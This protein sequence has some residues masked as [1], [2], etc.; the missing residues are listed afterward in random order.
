VALVDGG[1][2]V[3]GCPLCGGPTVA[4]FSTRDRNRA[5]AP[6]V[7]D[8]LRCVDCG[9]FH[10]DRVP[11]DLGPFYADEYFGLPGLDDLRAQAVAEH[12][13]IDLVRRHTVAAGRLVEIGPGDGIFALQALD[14]GFD[15]AA[16][17]PDRAAAAHLRDVLGVDVV[18]SAAP[19]DELAA[20]GPAQAIVAWH[21]LEHVRSP[22]AVLDAAA[23]TLLP[24]GVLVIATP[25]PRAF[26]FRVLG[27][28]W[29]HVDA[30]RHLFLLPHD[31][32]IERARAAGL[33][34]VE[35]TATDPGG[36]HWNA[37][38]WHYLLRRPGALYVHERVA[39]LA[40]AA[41]ARALAPIERHGLRGA[42]YTLVLRK[43]PA[44][45]AS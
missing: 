11:C 33:E 14:A 18:E 31:A 32:V 15:V 13:R 45:A 38:A 30:P 35:L 43:P 24:G 39:Q 6:T 27:P 19:E 23:A 20:L 26:G 21:V 2:R 40:G 1:P 29:P 36:L 4:A 22:W 42:A 17:E 16:I 37:F 34:P 25:N 41:I 9:A 28:R 44:A 7:F 12:Y 3:A 5:I 8:Y 10:L